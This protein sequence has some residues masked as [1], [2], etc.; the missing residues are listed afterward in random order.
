MERGL[1][2]L[3]AAF[4]VFVAPGVRGTAHLSFANNTEV[5]I[6]RT[7]CRVS[8]L[9]LETPNNCDPA[10]NGTCLFGSLVASPPVAP[11]GVNLSVE[12]RGNSMG[13]VALGL[14]VNAS[15]GGTM[16]FVCAQNSS[17]NGSFFFRTMMRNNTDDM[18]TPTETRVT[19]IRGS[20]KDNVIQCEFVVPGVNATSTRS[21]DATTFDVLLGTGTFNGN[22][23][24]PFNVSLNSGALNIAD[25]TS[26]TAGT[27]AA[28]TMT[29]S[30]T[31]AGTC[32]LH[33]HALLVL[34]SVLTLS[35]MQKA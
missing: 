24:G 32:V 11:N 19:E 2:L 27:T 25:P 33:P 15:E 5:N 17:N 26:N 31:T 20:V 29:S 30:S 28:P 13:Y 34:L 22:S 18:L 23:L 16:L 14:T 35:V 21:S 6:T 4:M 7:G 8:K 1:I 9:C 12:L 10:G 3:V